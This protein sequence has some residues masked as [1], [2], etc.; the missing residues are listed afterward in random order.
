MKPSAPLFQSLEGRSRRV[1]RWGAQARALLAWGDGCANS[2]VSRP[3]AVDECRPDPPAV[4]FCIAPPQAGRAGGVR[5]CADLMLKRR[6]QALRQAGCL[7]SLWGVPPLLPPPTLGPLSIMPILPCSVSPGRSGPLYRSRRPG[8]G[9]IVGP[10]PPRLDLFSLA[11]LD[12]V[13][14]VSPESPPV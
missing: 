3:L 10:L 1:C 4:E 2:S 6:A 14:T 7:L 5:P 8:P 11:T 9:A 12:P 13:T